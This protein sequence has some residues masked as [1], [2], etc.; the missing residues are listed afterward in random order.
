MKGNQGLSFSIP[1]RVCVDSIQCLYFS[2]LEKLVLSKCP[3]CPKQFT[4]SRVAPI[5]TP[6][7]LFANLGEKNISHW[8]W[9][10]EF[11]LSCQFYIVLILTAIRCYGCLQ[12]YFYCS[13]LL[14]QVLLILYEFLD[15][16]FP[17]SENNVFGVVIGITQNLYIVLESLH[18]LM[19]LIL[20]VHLQASELGCLQL[21]GYVGW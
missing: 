20:S 2:G 17:R 10:A 15:H 5:Q 4:G 9:S 7:M 19:I 1:W 16:F 6:N 13:G 18:M 3:Y 11:S 21:S 14:K 12:L 8:L